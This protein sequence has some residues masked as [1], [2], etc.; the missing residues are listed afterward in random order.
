L[1]ALASTAITVTAN[2]IPIPLAPRASTTASSSGQVVP[3]LPQQADLTT[4]QTYVNAAVTEYS[5]TYDSDLDHYGDLINQLVPV[6]NTLNSAIGVDNVIALDVLADRLCIAAPDQG[7]LCNELLSYAYAWYAIQQKGKTWQ[8]LAVILGVSRPFR[9]TILASRI[10]NL[11]PLQASNMKILA[12]DLRVGCLS[13]DS[14]K[15]SN[16]Q[17]EICQL[18]AFDADNLANSVIAAKVS[19][20][21]LAC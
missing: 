9:H 19:T 7:S 17:Y 15:F 3:N 13:A 6:A 4:A 16:A 8:Q 2:P 12:N 11:N 21:I 14:Q 18:V 5:G 1:A 10:A 20:L